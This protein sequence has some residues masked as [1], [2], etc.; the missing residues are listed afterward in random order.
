MKHLPQ[1]PSDFAERLRALP[2]SDQDEQLAILA[3]LADHQLD[4]IDTLQLDRIFTASDAAKPSGFETI[5]LAILASHTVAHLL[6]SIRVAGLRRHLIIQAYTGEYGQYYQDI[7]D[8]HSALYR[9][10]PDVVLLIASASQQITDIPLNADSETA[11]CILAER[12]EHLRGLWRRIQE[13]SEATVIQQTL[14]DV[15][16]PLFGSLDR[17][18]PGSPQRLV[19]RFNDLLTENA[20]AQ[21]V[22]LLDIESA[23]RLD[24]RDMW[25]DSARWLQGKY[26][27]A[28]VAA[29]VYGEM[30]ASIIAGDRGRSRKC[31]ILD[32]DNTLWGGVIGD[33]GIDGITLGHGNALGEAYLAVQEYALR[34]QERGIILAVCSK[35]D[36]MLARRVFDEHPDMRLRLSDIATFQAN[37]EDKSANIRRIAE[38]LNIGLESLVF[39]DDNPAE[40]ERIRASLP[41]VAVPELPDD[42]AEY[43]RCLARARYFEATAF[44]ADDLQRAEQ[45]H[46]QGGRAALQSS[47]QSLNDFLRSLDMRISCDCNAKVDMPRA[48]QLLAKTNQ[49]NMTQ[50]RYSPDQIARMIQSNSV[51]VYTFRLIDRFGDNGLVSVMLIRN[52][53]SDH[54]DLEVLNWV[55]SCRV[56][57]RQLEHEIMNKIVE[58]ARRDAR[59]TITGWFHPSER[60][61]VVA[62]LY[63]RCGFARST[64]GNDANS[65]WRLMIDDYQFAETHIQTEGSQ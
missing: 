52:N 46:A 26:E 34:L 8:P 28:P 47:A 14:L 9:F 13:N 51:S 39:L 57:G 24:G 2:E 4:F 35:N 49:F 16:E 48:A 44:T 31:L 22:L 64:D 1:K 55:M 23:C 54:S 21:R 10:G 62:D 6:P 53:S 45:Y 12:A 5:R 56:F 37:W 18:V 65:K 40:R 20:A 32:L 30:L 15:T 42:P 33:D 58:I 3:R 43:V 41:M 19:R 11:T 17:S 25:F 7:L 60:N 27:I 63:E 59:R 38:S 36:P 29:P 61:A 50:R